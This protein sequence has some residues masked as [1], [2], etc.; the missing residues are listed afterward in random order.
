MENIKQEI[1]GVDK[2]TL[3]YEDSTIKDLANDICDIVIDNYGTH[4]YEIFKRIVNERLKK[5][6]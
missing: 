6:L 1:E 2:Y 4:N 3:N 5:E